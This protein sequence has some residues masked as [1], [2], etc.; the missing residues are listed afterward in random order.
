MDFWTKSFSELK[1]RFKDVIA[2][3]GNHDQPGDN[4][5]EVKIH[6]MIPHKSQITVI[7]KPTII[8]N[9]LFMPYYHKEET[10]L[11][12][13]N[14]QNHSS[15]HTVVAHQTFQGCMYENGFYAKDGFGVENVQH[16]IISG[17]IHK[18][19]DLRNNQ[20]P[21]KMIYP[22]SPRWRNVSDTN[23]GK[24]LFDLHVNQ[25]TFQL[26]EA[27]DTNEVC[28]KMHH[29]EFV[30][31]E[32]TNKFLPKIKDN[33]RIVVDIKGSEAYIKSVLPEISTWAT[34]IRVFPQNQ[35][36]VTVSEQKSIEESLKDFLSNIK[37]P[38]GT[39]PDCLLSN[40]KRR[41]HAE[42]E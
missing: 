10:W 35:K 20:H 27:L 19:Q 15:F 3:V 13:Y 38:N 7:D 30:E 17:H 1:T 42:E 12:H 9:M 16:N 5:D 32:S 14:E 34:R 21:Y 6:S 29:I 23:E 36:K 28:S 18:F 22:G 33:D 4:T 40:V 8:D 24:S 31:P 11:N 37:A 41:L 2:L 39:H 25:D 26:A